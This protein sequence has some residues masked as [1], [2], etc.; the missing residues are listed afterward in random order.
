MEE[1]IKPSGL[2]F[3][4]RISKTPCSMPAPPAVNPSTVA[5]MRVA[6]LI[7]FLLKR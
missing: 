3:P 6:F 7:A 4:W 5:E 1:I 2:V